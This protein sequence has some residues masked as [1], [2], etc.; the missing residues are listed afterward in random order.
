[1]KNSFFVHLFEIPKRFIPHF[2]TEILSFPVSIGIDHVKSRS[3]S[4][5]I[6]FVS[7]ASV[8]FFLFVICDKLNGMH[9]ETGSSIYNVK[10]AATINNTLKMKNLIADDWFSSR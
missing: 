3:Q 8:S 4:V 9:F 7:F 10:I 5:C 6:E 1:M 2:R